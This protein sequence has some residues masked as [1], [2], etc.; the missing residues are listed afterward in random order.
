MERWRRR[1]TARNASRSRRYAE[2]DEIEA[3]GRPRPG[4]GLRANL[5]ERYS[6]MRSRYGRGTS[7]STTAPSAAITSWI[8]ASSARPTR[9]LLRARSAL[10]PG[11]FAT[12]VLSR[13]VC[14][15]YLLHDL[16]TKCLL[17]ARL[18][19]P[20]HFEMV[21]GPTSLPP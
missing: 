21:E 7:S 19:L 2:H 3:M 6:G 12:W 8:S 1:V 13:F 4:R 18:P 11:A 17:P 15:L 16:L 14:S 5:T 20:L 9:H 10:S